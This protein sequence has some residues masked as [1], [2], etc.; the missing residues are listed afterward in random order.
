MRIPV[1]LGQ[2]GRRERTALM[3]AQAQL[4]GRV[5]F[6]ARNTCRDTSEAEKD[7]LKNERVDEGNA[8][9]ASPNA[10]RSRSETIPSDVHGREA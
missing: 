9:C 4:E 7:A 6:I 8:E 3:T 5:A 1:M 2:V 10:P